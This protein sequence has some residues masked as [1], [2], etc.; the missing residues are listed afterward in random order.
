MAK[1]YF[2]LRVFFIL[3]LLSISTFAYSQIDISFNPP[4]LSSVTESYDSL[5]DISF[6]N[7]KKL[8]GQTLYLKSNKWD[9]AAGY[10]PIT[11]YDHISS[12]SESIY[13]RRTSISSNTDYNAVSGKYYYVNGFKSIIKKNFLGEKELYFIELKETESNDIIYIE[14]KED[15]NINK[16]FSIT[17]Y[18]TKLK[19]MHVG[20]EYITKLDNRGTDLV[21]GLCSFRDGQTN[22]NIKHG[23]LFLCTDISF[24]EGTP[25][26][27]YENN[28][29]GKCFIDVKYDKYYMKNRKIAELEKKTSEEHNIEFEKQIEKENKS[30]IAKYGKIN[31]NLIIQGKVKIGF[32]K[33]MCIESWGKP[34]SINKTTGK[35]GTHEQWVYEEGNYLYFDNGKLTTIQTHK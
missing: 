32:T 20:E 8:I 33:E 24:W 13:K 25:I 7:Y 16:Y 35:Y 28:V 31:G 17:G 19:E 3:T 5:E 4:D 22:Y 15:D 2:T 30:I 1:M 11:F 26:F 6:Q 9:K 29:H 23:E 12:N 27:V 21:K 10:Y 34:E 14:I 18:I